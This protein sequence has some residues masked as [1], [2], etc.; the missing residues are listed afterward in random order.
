[1]KN[2]KPQRATYQLCCCNKDEQLRKAL[3]VPSNFSRRLSAKDLQAIPEVYHCFAKIRKKK[4]NSFSTHLQIQTKS[5][6]SSGD[7]YLQTDVSLANADELSRGETFSP[8]SAANMIPDVELFSSVHGEID[9]IYMTCPVYFA[10]EKVYIEHIYDLLINL[11]EVSFT[12]VTQRPPSM[13]IGTGVSYAHVIDDLKQIEEEFIDR[14]ATL[15]FIDSEGKEFTQWTADPFLQGQS[16]DRTDTEIIEPHLFDRGDDYLLAKKVATN[17]TKVLPFSFHGGNILVGSNFML[18]GRDYFDAELELRASFNHRN[19]LNDLSLSESESELLTEIKVHLSPLKNRDLI[20]I[21]APKPSTLDISFGS[22]ED[23]YDFGQ[24]P[25]GENQPFAHLDLFLTL[26]GKDNLNSPYRIVLGQVVNAGSIDEGIEENIIAPLNEWL[27]IIKVSLEDNGFEVHRIDMPL[28]HFTSA[29]LGVEWRIL[30]YNNCLVEVS[31]T[32]RC[33]WMPTY[34]SEMP[35]GVNIDYD[36]D[37]IS[38]YDKQASEVYSA[39]GFEVVPLMNFIRHMTYFGAAHC[40][41]NTSRRKRNVT[42]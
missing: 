33:I 36:L 39:L 9:H 2:G 8:A 20:L 40:I 14:R 35:T 21:D 37:G 32:K 13:K 7:L 25:I 24:I 27:D 26:I 23:G 6:L 3:N 38:V 31:P 41:T 11:P 5:K 29:I 28:M 22:T 1:M 30:S 34:G 12:I 15:R 10:H 19:K 42:S 17:A 16:I 18:L 4:R